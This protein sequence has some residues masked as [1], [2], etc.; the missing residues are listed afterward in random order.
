MVLTG[1]VHAWS[2]AGYVHA[3]SS[4]GMYMHGPLLGMYMHGPLLDM[5]IW[6]SAAGLSMMCSF[7]ICNCTA[8]FIVYDVTQLLI[9]VRELFYS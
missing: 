9:F 3:W 5:Y 1:Y 7:C 6:S 8:Q 4:L 2:Y